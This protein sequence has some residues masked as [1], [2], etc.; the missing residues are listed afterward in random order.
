MEIFDVAI[1]G[2]GASGCIAAIKIL[3]RYKNIAIIDAS[4]KIAKKILSTGNGRCN[5]TNKNMSSN[6]FNQNIDSFSKRFNQNDTLNFFSSLGL[7]CYHD[8]EG[9]VYPLSNSAKSVVD[10]LNNKI[11]STGAKCFLE[12]K[13]EK[14]T[15]END[16]FAIKTTENLI[17]AKK[18]VFALGGNSADEILKNF[19]ISCKKFVPSLVSLKINSSKFLNNLR[20]SNVKVSAFDNQNNSMVENGEILFKDGGISGICIFNLSTLFARQNKFEGKINIDLLPNYSLNELKNLLVSRK[21]LNVSINKF[22]DGLFVS[23]LAYEILNRCKLDENRNS[24]TLTNEEISAFANTI[25]NLNFTVK[26][27]FDNN[28]VFSGGINLKDLTE[29]LEHKKV[30]N[31][32]FCGE[33]CDVD[34][35]CGG[36]NLQWAWTSGFIVGENIW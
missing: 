30:K 12:Q 34:G 25:K 7:V 31:L 15:K 36:Y 35:I 19:N 2:S 26:G 10:V 17:K 21:T 22:F 9:R 18:V 23:P 3:E 4:N 20:V 27:H 32:Y 1:L 5:L 8:E 14:I 29:N 13:I 33:V 11:I 6:F 16:I 24:K 28:Q